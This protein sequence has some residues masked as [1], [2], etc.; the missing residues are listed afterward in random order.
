VSS[1]NDDAPR[2][3]VPAATVYTALLLRNPMALLSNYSIHPDDEVDG[4]RGDVAGRARTN[5]KVTDHVPDGR[6]DRIRA[7]VGRVIPSLRKKDSR[8]AKTISHQRVAEGRKVAY[9]NLTARSADKPGNEGAGAVD[10]KGSY[11]AQTGWAPVYFLPWEKAGGIVELTIPRKGSDSSPHED[12]D[13]FFTAAINGCSVFFQG[14]PDNPTI[15]HAGGDTGRK[16]VEAGADFWR[17]V[18]TN[19]ADL[20]RGQFKSEV[21]KTEYITTPG[22]FAD[23]GSLTTQQA[24]EYQR[25]LTDKHKTQLTIQMVSP[26]GCVMGVRAGDEWAFYLQENATI[27]FMYLDKHR[28]EGNRMQTVARP[29]SVREVYPGGGVVDVKAPLMQV[30]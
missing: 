27:V 21:N 13:L 22:V 19:F 6:M 1:A 16:D 30:N 11:T 7:A 3:P 9:V 29:M 8:Y 17:E 26:W 20:S 28:P 25:F 10:V 12:P 4:Y 15:Y 2:L 5:L 24:Q 14:E 18:L 23:D